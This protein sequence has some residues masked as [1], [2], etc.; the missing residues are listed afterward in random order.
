MNE[1]YICEELALPSVSMVKF[2]KHVKWKKI[3]HRKGMYSISIKFK[4]I[5]RNILFVDH[6][7]VGKV[8]KYL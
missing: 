4:N 7:Y 5:I 3:T 2:Q 6:R 1:H 8:L